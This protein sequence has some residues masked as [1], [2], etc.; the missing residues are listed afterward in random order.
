[1]NLSEL[2][3]QCNR[4]FWWDDYPFGMRCAASRVKAWWLTKMAMQASFAQ[5]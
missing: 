5:Q 3:H 4:R 2:A 1:M